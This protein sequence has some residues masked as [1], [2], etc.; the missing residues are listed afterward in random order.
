MIWSVCLLHSQ[1]SMV[2]IEYY[3]K[4]WELSIIFAEFSRFLWMLSKI[5]ELFENFLGRLYEVANSYVNDQNW[6]LLE[7]PED[8]Y[9]YILFS[10]IL[11][12]LF[13]ISCNLTR[14]MDQWSKSEEK[15]LLNLHEMKLVNYR[16]ITF[17]GMWWIKVVITI[18]VSLNAFNYLCEWCLMK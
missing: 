9:N 7:I 17:L 8:F 6:I 16:R 2:N 10:E 14:V 12:R 3:Y 15:W 5:I 4:L 11:S 1:R 13:R 18:T